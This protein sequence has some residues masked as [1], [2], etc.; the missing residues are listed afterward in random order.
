MHTPNFQFS[1]YDDYEE[2]LDGLVFCIFSTP[3][4]GRAENHTRATIIIIII[5]IITRTT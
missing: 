4:M 3:S 5:I 2:W 1:P